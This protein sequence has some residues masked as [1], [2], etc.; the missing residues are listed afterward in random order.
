MIA[1]DLSGLSARPLPQSC[2]AKTLVNA[3]VVSH[4]DYC[5]GLLVGLRDKQLNR[6]QAVMNN[7]ALLICHSR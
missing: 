6:L 3:F 4:L 7:A 2:A 1:S 5:N